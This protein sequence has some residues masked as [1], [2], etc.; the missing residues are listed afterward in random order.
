MNTAMRTVRITQVQ[1]L[2]PRV[3]ASVVLDVVGMGGKMA[4]T[5]EGRWEPT[6]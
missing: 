1:A 4:G 5:A 6:P 3:P 2:P